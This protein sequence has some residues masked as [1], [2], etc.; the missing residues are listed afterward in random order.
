MKGSPGFSRHNDV[1]SASLENVQRFDFESLK[2][3]LCSSSYA[4]E[5]GNPNFERMLKELHDIFSAHNE[6]GVVNFDYD[7]RVYYGQLRG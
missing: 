2:G 7:T 1:N 3:R 5:P 4:P 6:N